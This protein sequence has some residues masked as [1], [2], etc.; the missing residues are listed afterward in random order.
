MICINRHERISSS[1]VL[2]NSG[3]RLFAFLTL[4]VVVFAGGTLKALAQQEEMFVLKEAVEGDGVPL[5]TKPLHRPFAG[6]GTGI[7]KS[8][9]KFNIF[10]GVVFLRERVPRTLSEGDAATP[11]QLESDLHPRWVRK[12][13]FGIN[14]PIRQIKDAIKP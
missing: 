2:K 11:S 5:A 13:M 6:I 8:P 4:L 14:I 1:G 7:F 9:I 3:P 12:F 10:A